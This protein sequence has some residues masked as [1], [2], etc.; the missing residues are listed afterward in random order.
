MDY[1][2][3]STS[4]HTSAKKQVNKRINELTQNTT[5]GI[6]S[7]YRCLQ[8][9]GNIIIIIIITIIII[10]IIIIIIMRRRKG[11]TMM[12]IIMMMITFEETNYSYRN[13]EIAFNKFSSK[14]SCVQS[15]SQKRA[16]CT[17]SGNHRRESRKCENGYQG[18]ILGSYI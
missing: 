1:N 7:S 17:P 15:S 13:Q 16:L 9:V 4:A 10:I 11:M 5:S 6:Q 8:G 18:G 12:M 3:R 14:K 2:V